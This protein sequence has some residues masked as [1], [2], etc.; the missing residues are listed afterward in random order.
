MQKIFY[1]NSED[2]EEIE[3]FTAKYSLRG[4]LYYLIDVFGKFELNRPVLK[5][6]KDKNNKILKFVMLLNENTNNRPVFS[7]SLTW[8]DE[9]NRD[10]P[11]HRIIVEN[12]DGVCNHFKGSISVDGT[13]RVLFEMVTP[14][15]LLSS[16]YEL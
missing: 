16:V 8:I 6:V 14:S 15:M 5:F 13:D 12:V 4:T 1:I 9:F 7:Q 3:N 11:P 2:L 10:H